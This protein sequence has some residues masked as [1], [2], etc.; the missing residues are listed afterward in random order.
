MYNNTNAYENL[1]FTVFM[2]IS[3]DKKNICIIYQ[4]FEFVWIASSEIKFPNL[5]ES[6]IIFVLFAYTWDRTGE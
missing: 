5:K 6:F 4:N 1:T 3:S 2:K